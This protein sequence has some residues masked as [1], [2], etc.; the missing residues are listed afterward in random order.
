MTMPAAAF[1]G[2]R[3]RFGLALRRDGGAPPAAPAAIRPLPR[4][5]PGPAVPPPESRDAALAAY[6]DGVREAF[7]AIEPALREMASFQ[8][9]SDFARRAQAL[10]RERLG[11]ELPAAPLEQAWA[12]GLDVRAL[13]AAC[14]FETVRRVNARTMAELAA[15]RDATEALRRF[16]RDCGFHRV[17]VAHCSDGRLLGTVRYVLRLPHT[18]VRREAYAGTRFDV[19]AS[20][21]HWIEAELERSRAGAPEP[22]RYLKVAAYHYSGSRRDEGCAAH[23]HDRHAA[24]QAAL[25]RLGEFRQAI[26]N[27]FCCGASVATLL[28]GVD[29]D[30]DAL[31]LHLPD[32]RG[33]LSLH[34]SVDNAAVAAAVAAGAPA[35]R[36]IADA[37]AAAA[38]AQGW[39]R[40]QGAPEPGM[41][42]LCAC[43]LRN[44][45]AQIAYVRARHGAAYP[46]IG[47][48]E[49]FL[50]AGNGYADEQLRNV[51]FYVRLDTVEEAAA[52]LDVGLRILSAHLA[53][54]GLAVP[55]LIHCGYDGRVPGSRERAA[56]RTQRLDSAIRAR[57]PAL[58]REGLLATARAVQDTAGSGALEFIGGLAPR[59]SGKE[60]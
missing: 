26:E 33:E 47:H 4:T 15:E 59:S 48:A 18:A 2:P 1:A 22:T 53:E 8:H 24:A 6:E 27:R 52:D 56:A 34:R 39:G 58:A 46:E 12:R 7:A 13:Y 45:L 32:G 9:A 40:G 42:A 19:E 11:F 41:L 49:R 17:D 50:S 29:T 10:A 31:T 38:A 23:A 55:A 14:V 16:F 60:S 25:A 43:L 51:A 21:Q 28:L 30:T 35:E 5:V 36:A 3:N 54:R 57:Y 37:L 20:V 44:N